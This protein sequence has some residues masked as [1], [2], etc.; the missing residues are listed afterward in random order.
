M[1][2]ALGGDLGA[3]EDLPGLGVAGLEA[4]LEALGPGR[5]ARQDGEADREEE[6]ALQ[7]R[8]EE[9]EKAEP[10]KP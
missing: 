3:G 6:H 9:A 8:Q 10:R 4:E 5:V 2:P 1:H 7:D